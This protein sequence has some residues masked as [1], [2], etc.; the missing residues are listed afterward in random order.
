MQITRQH[1][2]GDAACV[3]CTNVV[4]GVGQQV[5][6]GSLSP[7]DRVM[8]PITNQRQACL[9]TLACP[10]DHAIQVCAGLTHLTEKHLGHSSAI[11]QG[12]TTDEIVGLNRGGTLV[13]GQ[14]AGVTV[15]LCRAGFL[16]EAHATMD[17]NAE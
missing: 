6:N 9:S 14:D 15:I 13:D 4:V 8:K 1:Q 11:P 2:I 10:G 5:G 3:D 17:L 7:D 16:D 12:F